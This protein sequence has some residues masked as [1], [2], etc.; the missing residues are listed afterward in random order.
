MIEGLKMKTFKDFI[1]ETKEYR[2]RVVGH[3]DKVGTEYIITS[4]DVKSAHK[5]AKE[6]HTNNYGMFGGKA[7]VAST[8]FKNDNGNWEII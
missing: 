1:I 8:S 5:Q 3:G 2:V 7:R 4:S 6:H